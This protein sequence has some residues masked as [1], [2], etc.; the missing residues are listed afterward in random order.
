M[1]GGSGGA[2]SGGHSLPGFQPLSSPCTRLTAAEGTDPA[3]VTVRRTP[4]PPARKT[5]RAVDQ[6]S[7]LLPVIEGRGACRHPDGATQLVRSALRTFA[8]DTRWHDQHGPCYGVR[9]DPL[10]P[11][12]G[13]DEREWD[14]R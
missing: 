3:H 11:V 5:T 12:P 1:T 6:I 10:L 2:G 9:R 14:W 8:A 13:D 7:R 4:A